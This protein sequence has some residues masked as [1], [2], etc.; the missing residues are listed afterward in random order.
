MNGVR[1]GGFKPG[2][3][4]LIPAVADAYGVICA[5][6]NAYACAIGRHKFHY[7]TLLRALGIRCPSMCG[8]TLTRR[9]ASRAAFAKRDRIAAGVRGS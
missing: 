1:S 7:A 6:S 5:N 2:R 8:V 4:S 3:K 9:P